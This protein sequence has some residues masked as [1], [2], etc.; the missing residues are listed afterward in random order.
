MSDT[1]D[2]KKNGGREGVV[3]QLCNIAFHTDFLGLGN[4]GSNTQCQISIAMTATQGG[5]AHGGNVDP[6]WY[7]DSS[8][9]NH[10]AH[11]LDRLTT[12]EPYYSTDQVYVANGIGM[13]IHNIGH[14]LLPTPS[15]K[16][17]NLNR[18]LHV[19]NDTP[20]LLDCTVIC[21]I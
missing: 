14:A 4:D 20:I 15:S 21:S 5:R 11:E 16:P 17:L 6:A 3:Y 19:S 10:I 13:C 9:T 1:P 12:R 8:V 7:A 2:A 18:A